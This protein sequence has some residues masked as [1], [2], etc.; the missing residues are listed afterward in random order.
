MDFVRILP[1]HLLRKDITVS[2]TEHRAV[3]K[4]EQEERKLKETLQGIQTLQS[5]TKKVITRDIASMSRRLQITLNK[6]SAKN[7]Y[8]NILFTPDELEAMQKQDRIAARKARNRKLAR[9]SNDNS[10][11]AGIGRMSPK[12]KQNRVDF[13]KEPI[14]HQLDRHHKDRDSSNINRRRASVT[15][16]QS[17]NKHSNNEGGVMT[18]YP[19]TCIKA[20]NDSY[21]GNED[22]DLESNSSKQILT[23]L[24]VNTIKRHSRQYEDI[25]VDGVT[26]SNSLVNF[27]IDSWIRNTGDPIIQATDDEDGGDIS[28][29]DKEKLED[30]ESNDSSI[31]IPLSPDTTKPAID[32]RVLALRNQEP[33]SG[34]R[35]KPNTTTSNKSLC[36]GKSPDCDNNDNIIKPMPK[37]K[38][39]FHHRS[40]RDHHDSSG[41][42]GCRKHKIQDSQIDDD[43]H[44][45]NGLISPYVIQV[46]ENGGT[47]NNNNQKINCNRSQDPINNGI[48]IIVNSEKDACDDD[49]VDGVRIDEKYEDDGDNG[50]FTFIPKNE[51]QNVVQVESNATPEP[52]VSTTTE[53]K[54]RQKNDQHRNKN[55]TISKP[56]KIIEEDDQQSESSSYNSTITRSSNRR[57]NYTNGST[58]LTSKRRYTIKKQEETSR[59]LMIGTPTSTTTRSDA[60]SKRSHHPKQNSMGSC[61]DLNPADSVKNQ[62]SKKLAKRLTLMKNLLSFTRRIAPPTSQYGDDAASSIMNTPN[63]NNN[64]NSSTTSQNTTSKTTDLLHPLANMNAKSKAILLQRRRTLT[65][66]NNIV[67]PGGWE[68]QHQKNTFQG[69]RELDELS[70]VSSSADGTETDVYEA[71]RR[72]KYLRIPQHLTVDD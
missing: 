52:L 39:E 58:K 15:D 3:T 71:L 13:T 17:A 8:S 45:K 61:T 35:D 4:N 64:N 48:T 14:V 40:I 18:K 12:R 27:R 41:G 37:Y 7:S 46:K 42:V 66:E 67:I 68:I 49:K 28:D 9:L 57:V 5:F 24:T 50:E 6:A 44:Q 54:T 20:Y 22:S 32:P 43:D 59:R 72:C 11:A 30:V 21:S 34:Q 47:N 33:F 26:G 25:D 1:C 38:L 31:I 69:N 23:K 29:S 19:N 51:N 63:N 62:A 56:T 70:Y 10:G 2:Y 53:K 16:G 36:D 55:K 65:G 60:K